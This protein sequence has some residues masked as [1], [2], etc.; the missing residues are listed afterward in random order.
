MNETVDVA[1]GSTPAAAGRSSRSPV[2]RVCF[3]ALLTLVFLAAAVESRT[4]PPL[5]RYFPLII[6]SGGLVATTLQL[7]VE[8]RRSRRPAEPGGGQTAIMDVGSSDE[9]LPRVLLSAAK[10][11]SLV[12]G[13]WLLGATGGSVIYVL[14]FLRFEGRWRWRTAFAGTVMTGVLLLL[15]EEYLNFYWP[16]GLFDLESTIRQLLGA[17]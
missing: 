16:T 13:I 17:Q 4:F 14:L 5:A 15:L 12:P 6:A 3:T 7:I 8:V 9:P 2:G 1:A 11:G 10:I